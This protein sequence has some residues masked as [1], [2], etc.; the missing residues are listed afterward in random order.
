MGLGEPAFRLAD[1]CGKTTDGVGE[2][3]GGGPATC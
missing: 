3:P 1:G 2:V